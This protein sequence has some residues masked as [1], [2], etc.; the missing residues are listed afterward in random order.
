M[1][2]LNEANNIIKTVKK[3]QLEIEKMK[4]ELRITSNSAFLKGD[5]ESCRQ[6]REVYH[7]WESNYAHLAD[8]FAELPE[9]I[10]F[11]RKIDEV[12]KMLADW[13]RYLLPEFWARLTAA[14]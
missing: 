13:Q 1:N 7:R 3:Y 10:M 8:N 9:V 12:N 2:L 4:T 6:F 14:V 11:D 5:E